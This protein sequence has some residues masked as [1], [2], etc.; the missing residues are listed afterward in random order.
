M[1]IAITF[2]ICTQVGPRKHVLCEGAHW[3]HLANAIEPS[4]H[5]SDVACCQITLATWFNRD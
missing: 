2:G 4:M 1:A 3:C 5:V